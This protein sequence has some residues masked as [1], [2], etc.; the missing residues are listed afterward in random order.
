MANLGLGSFTQGLGQGLLQGNQMRMQKQQIAQ[1][2]K[3]QEQQLKLQKSQIIMDYGMKLLSPDMP[4]TLRKKG[5]SQIGEAWKLINPQS[6]VSFLNNVDLNSSE[7]KKA[8]KILQIHYD[9]LQKGEETLADFQMIVRASAQELSQSQAKSLTESAD[10]VAKAYELE[11]Y[12][13]KPT[14]TDIDD[15]VSDAEMARA[16]DPKAKARNIDRLKFK[17]A[18][19]DEVGETTRAKRQEEAATAEKIEYNKKVGARLAEIATQADLMAAKGEI[20]PEQKKNNAKSRMEGNLAKLGNFYQELDSMNAIL[21]T[22]N[23]SVDNILAAAKSSTLGQSV[24]RITGSE[25]QSIRQ[26]IRNIIPLVVQDI[27]QATD[28]G[29]RGLDSEKELEFYMQA[30][31]DPKKSI[32]SNIAALVVLSEAYG[33]GQIAEQLR[34]LTNDSLIGLIK[35]AGSTILNTKPRKNENLKTNTTKTPEEEAAEY[36]NS[37]GG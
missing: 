29:A 14:P 6:D 8:F 7:A 30:A 36:L 12:T 26:S 5:L 23:N 21:N 4:D 3:N 33:N 15:F 28:M 20:S 16:G 22:K 34:R 19:A 2:Q 24:G 17:R 10:A 35:D 13:S 27:R 31:S 18:Q 1:Q 32:Q 9:K 11:K 25:A 37:I